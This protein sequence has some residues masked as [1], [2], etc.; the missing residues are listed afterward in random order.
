M[1]CKA[2]DSGFRICMNGLEVAIPGLTIASPAFGEST[3]GFHI[4]IELLA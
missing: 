3:K 2:W 4:E 1:E